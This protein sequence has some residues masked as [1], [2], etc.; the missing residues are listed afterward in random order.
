MALYT[1]S[2]K[3]NL[4]EFKHTKPEMERELLALIVVRAILN[5]FSAFGTIFN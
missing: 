3:R 2:Q 5:M 4:C 1:D